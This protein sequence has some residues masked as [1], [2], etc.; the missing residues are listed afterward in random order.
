MNEVI[1]TIRNVVIFGIILYI[2]NIGL[3]FILDKILSLFNL[4]ALYDTNIILYGIVI[5]VLGVIL[6][7]IAMII[8]KKIVSIKIKI[9][10]EEAKKMLLILLIIFLIKTVVEF[11]LVYNNVLEQEKELNNAINSLEEVRT[12]E[13]YKYF[14]K[15]EKQSMNKIYNAYTEG[16]EE[17][18][19]LNKQRLDSNIIYSIETVF[20]YI[21]C[22]YAFGLYLYRKD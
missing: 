15:E 3:N 11:V 14:S 7:L 1:K 9:N 4:D 21:V 16:K 22:L 10:Y 2:I 17:I 19:E 18:I 6:Y 12:S 13:G 8:T 20:I 5:M